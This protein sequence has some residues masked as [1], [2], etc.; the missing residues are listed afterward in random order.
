MPSDL[1]LLVR[2]AKFIREMTP[3]KVDVVVVFREGRWVGEV[4]GEPVP[5][6]ITRAIPADV[7]RARLRSTIIPTVFKVDPLRKLSV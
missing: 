2:A 4:T 7:D 3:R 6:S 5:P 1:P